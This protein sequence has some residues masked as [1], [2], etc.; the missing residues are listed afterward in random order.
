MRG[1]RQAEAAQP[2]RLGAREMKMDV[3]PRTNPDFV[4]NTPRRPALANRTQ[5][6]ARPLLL[7]RTDRPANLTVA[8]LTALPPLVTLNR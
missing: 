6:R 7:V 1:S 2:V 3:R 8:F 4:A 5:I